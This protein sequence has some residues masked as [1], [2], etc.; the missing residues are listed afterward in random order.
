MKV[1]NFLKYCI[2]KFDSR[3]YYYLFSVTCNHSSY[4]EIKLGI[5]FS[6]SCE[7]ISSK[8][9]KIAFLKT[10]EICLTFLKCNLKTL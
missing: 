8:L 3:Q 4:F 7:N 1:S 10:E 2:T 9:I 5:H 6:I